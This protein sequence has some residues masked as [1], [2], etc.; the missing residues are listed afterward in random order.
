MGGRIFLIAFIAVFFIGI[1][2]TGFTAEAQP[3]EKPVIHEEKPVASEEKPVIIDSDRIEYSDAHKMVHGYGNVIVTHGDMTMT[4]DKMAFDVQNKEAIA[5]GNVCLYQDES[6]FRGNYGHYDFETGK[7]TVSDVRFTSVPFYGAAEE[8][9]KTGKKIFAA[10]KGSFTTCPFEKPH[11]RIEAKRITIY[12]DERIV[13]N[14][15]VFYIGNFPLLYLPYYS[16]SLKEDRPRV[17]VIPGKTK[18]WGIYVLTTWRYEFNDNFKGVIHIDWREKMGIAEGVTHEYRTKK[19]GEGVFDF[20]YMQERL[21]GIPEGQKAKEERYRISLIHNWE[22]EYSIDADKEETET[23]TENKNALK[24]YKPTGG[25]YLWK[26]DSKSTSNARVFLEYHKRSDI[27]FDKDFFYEEYTKNPQ[28]KTQ[29]SFVRKFPSFTFNIHGRVRINPFET[30][31]QKLPEVGFDMPAYQLGGT[32]FRFNNKTSFINFNKKTANVGA[33]G[34]HSYFYTT[35]TQ[36]SRFDTFNSLSYPTKLPGYFKWLD[37]TP[38]G[39]VRGTFYTRNAANTKRNFLRGAGGAGIALTTK[40]WRTWDIEKKLIGIEINRLRHLI[41]PTVTY[42]YACVPSVRSNTLYQF[43]SID[44]LTAAKVYYFALNNKLQTKWRTDEG[45][46]RAANLIDFNTWIY[47]HPPRE[48]HKFSNVFFSLNL[49]PFKWLIWDGSASYNWVTKN[50][51]NFNLTFK[52]TKPLLEINATHSFFVNRYSETAFRALYHLSPKWQVGCYERY[53]FSK[54]SLN[55]QEYFLSRDLH[56]WTVEI[57]YNIE[58]G[59][60]ESIMIAIRNKAFPQM[61]IEYETSY[62]RRKIGSQSEPVY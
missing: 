26:M 2:L 61:P 53:D 39:N 36:A 19:F 12:L 41:T 43:D 37:V 5:D 24:L 14:H 33:T 22:T 21:K 30:V 10:K 3:E 8:A 49:M 62:H 18:D 16:Y 46:L 6:T 1:L 47:Y 38:Y 48:E 31:T 28:P 25:G 20:Y 35:T 60:G 15:V 54:K 50:F 59:Y 58:R 13:A 51:E 57:T 23:E 32:K 7:G 27:T 9:Q 11:Y 52:F 17:T 40:V 56:D 34:G 55:E 44:N 42:A 4:A 45:D 29:V